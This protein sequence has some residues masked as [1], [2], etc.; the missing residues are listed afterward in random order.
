ME[1][2]QL[3]NEKSFEQLKARVAVYVARFDF[4]KSEKVAKF[5]ASFIS[6]SQQ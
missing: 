4:E 3:H 1:M 5:I 2:R 6:K